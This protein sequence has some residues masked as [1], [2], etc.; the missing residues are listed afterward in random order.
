MPI[1]LMTKVTRALLAATIGIA[2]A[3]AQAPKSNEPDLVWSPRANLSDGLQELP[4]PDPPNEVGANELRNFN[5]TG[6]QALPGDVLI[7]EPGR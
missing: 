2:S 5:R 7:C 4:R 1:F 6:A 3:H